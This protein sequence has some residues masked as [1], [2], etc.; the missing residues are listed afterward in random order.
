LIIAAKDVPTEV[1]A[2]TGGQ[3][4]DVVFDTVDGV[5]FRRAVNSLAD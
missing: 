5:M 1:R 2:T 4:P 3:G